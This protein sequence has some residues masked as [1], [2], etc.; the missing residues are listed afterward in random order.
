MNNVYEVLYLGYYSDKEFDLHLQ[1][2]TDNDMQR[3]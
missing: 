1:I 3:R 2:V